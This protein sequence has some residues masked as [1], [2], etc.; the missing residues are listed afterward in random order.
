MVDQKP[1]SP[2]QSILIEPSP[3]AR[4][5]SWTKPI[6]QQAELLSMTISMMDADHTRRLVRLDHVTGVETQAGWFWGELRLHT[7]EQES[8][9]L[10][11]IRKRDLPKL[12]AQ[13]LKRHR[14]CLDVL[15]I[16]HEHAVS[17]IQWAS[18]LDAGLGGD[19][20]VS[21]SSAEAV[22]AR[23]QVLK[24]ILV[25]PS[26]H[27][28][29]VVPPPIIR[30]LETIHTFLAD[31]EAFREQ[32]NARFIPAE[33]DRFQD[34]LDR[35]ESNP[36]TR[37]QR[38][39]VIT[40]EDNTR[41]VA[42][43]GAGKTS[44]LM[45]KVG[46]LLKKGLCKP[47]QLLLIA[48]NRRAAQ[49][50][51]ERLRKRIGVSIQ[52][53]TFHALGLEIIAQAEGRKPSVTRTAEAK[54]QLQQTLQRIVAELAKDDD[55]FQ[56]VLRDYF[57][58]FFVPYK[59]PFE[60]QT[61]GEYYEYLKNQELITLRG[62]RVKSFEECEI[63]NF[64]CLNGIPYEYERNYEVDTATVTHRR[65]Q[66]DFYLTES[67]IY[68]EHFGIDR[69][70]NTPPFVNRA[71][72]IEGV[73][74][75]RQLHATHGTRL[76]ETHSYQKREGTLLQDLE[77][78]L[79][80]LGVVFRPISAEQALTV[81]KN[82]NRFNPFTDLLGTFLNHFKG[83]GYT[84]QGLRQRAITVGQLNDRLEAFLAVFGP[85]VDRYN[86]ELA[87][88][89]EVDFNDMILQAARHAETE[90]FQSPFTCILVDEFQD[91]STGRARLIKALREQKKSH[92]LFCVGDDWQAIY[93]F[94]GS[95]I[96]LMRDFTLHFGCT[97]TVFLD[98][99]FRFND[100]IESV[101]SR[102]IQTNP[103]Q[104]RKTIT[105]LRRAS[106]AKVVIH[107]PRGKGE[108][109]LPAILQRIADEHARGRASIKLLGRY[110]FEGDDLPWRE[111]QARFPR[112]A[113]EFTTVHK[114]KG[115]EADFIVVLGMRAGR[116]G[117]PSEIADD[118]LL[119]IVLAEPESYPNA[120][121]RR[122]FYVALTRA[123]HAVHL[124]AD[125]SRPSGFLSEIRQYGHDLV[126]A[127]GFAALEPVTCPRCLAG[128]LVQ[129]T[130]Y[131]G[132]F[133][134]CTNFPLCDYTTEACRRCGVGLMREQVSEQ[135]VICDDD[136]C[137]HRERICP[138]CGTGYLVERKGP[139]G[140]FLGC[141]NYA[142]GHC[143][144]T[145]KTMPG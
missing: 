35:I 87:H 103:G 86:T 116:Y 130:S 1:D 42:G 84:V 12:Q 71:T 141:T 131:H 132:V 25:L 44:V 37:S 122:L 133:Y 100:R 144:Y 137:G 9:V 31:P 21:H 65:Y 16:V 117:F 34:Y 126:V 36:L 139:Y 10:G 106:Q 64:F 80:R 120:E 104:I 19:Y 8:F 46:Y 118:P 85:V 6:Y 57:Q 93:R 107:R 109:I 142:G 5:F 143:R 66:P 24:P 30:A 61:L 105:S 13:F 124:V 73:R 32:A 58:S 134:G 26:K 145:E 23:F 28:K 135:V 59:S 79:H 3:W 41:V 43:A 51:R 127:E 63:A 14:A 129:R 78:T 7:N 62:E 52:A 68:I 113:V 2:D 72:Y 29:D 47:E 125:H 108:A 40:H 75:K 39:A 20:W 140:V 138:D 82:S 96:A 53:S 89:G 69:N 11:G 55:D 101:A 95:D 98:S 56:Q 76:I 92:R 48:F 110:T 49:E 102:F 88:R 97:E 15:R 67:G 4:W 136:R 17:M 22:A 81:L 112:F 114:A 91:I 121:E 45:A 119:N 70:G 123:R 128:T 90:R 74:W 38:L 50:L 18:E 77:N 115:L 27:L 33:L 111:I 60:F 99:T 54:T 94:A 83:G